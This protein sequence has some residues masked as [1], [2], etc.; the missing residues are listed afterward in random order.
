MHEGNIIKNL[1]I[2][3]GITQAELAKKA[4]VTQQHISGIELGNIMPSIKTYNKILSVL[5]FELY[6]RNT[7]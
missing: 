7:S 3:R 5:G 4:K 1:R 6:L 2:K